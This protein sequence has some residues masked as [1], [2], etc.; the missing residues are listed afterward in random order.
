MQATTQLA[1]R[2][3]IHPLHRRFR[4]EVAQLRYPRLGGPHGKF[5]TDPFFANVPSLSRCTMG[6]LYTNDVHFTK[7]YPMHQKSE[8]AD[9]LVQLMQ[10][11]WIPSDLHSD[12]AKELTQGKMGNL[13]RKFWIKPSQSEPYSPWQVRAELCIREESNTMMSSRHQPSALAS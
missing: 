12:D 9:T 3:A 1:L 13:L 11:V 10:D 8:V 4:T 2:Q 7:F 6:Q 5:H